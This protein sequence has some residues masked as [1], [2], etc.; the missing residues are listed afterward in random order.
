[1]LPGFSVFIALRSSLF[2]P[3][4][5]HALIPQLLTVTP[6]IVVCP[7]QLVWADARGLNAEIVV[8]DLLALFDEREAAHLKAGVAATPVAALF[9]SIYCANQ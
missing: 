7:N 3:D 5:L 2:S 4:S 6:R 1:M 8:R 9:A